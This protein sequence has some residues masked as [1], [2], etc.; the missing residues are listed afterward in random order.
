MTMDKYNKRN[1]FIHYNTTFLLS[2]EQLLYK[3]YCL[4]SKTK[5]LTKL[6]KV[7]YV[8]LID[9]KLKV[10]FRHKILL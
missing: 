7:A 2:G 5:K 8:E 9:S 3:V 6:S 10:H 1:I 4:N